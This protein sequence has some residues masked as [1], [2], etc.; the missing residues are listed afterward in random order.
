MKKTNHL[1]PAALIGITLAGCAS[2]GG[3]AVWVPPPGSEV[4]VNMEISAGSK[5]RVYIQDG[6]TMERPGVSVTSP[7]CYFTLD[8][9]APAPGD[10]FSIQPGTFRV[11]KS[12]RV[13]SSASA[14]DLQYAGRAG[15]DQTLSTIM[16]L[17]DGGQAEVD[18]LTCSRWGMISEDGWLT[19]K[20]MQ[21]T[22]SPLVD[23]R[24]E[25]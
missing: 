1:V 17:G 8:R 15:S 2:T 5:S 11:T 13:R 21:S 14:I 10:T 3:N 6:R 19:I 9:V 16:E 4:Q 24:P 12:Y 25:V 23:I 22:L 7:Y 20:E 18:R